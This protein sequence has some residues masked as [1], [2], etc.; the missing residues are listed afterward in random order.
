MSDTCFG[1][2]RKWA[3]LDAAAGASQCARTIQILTEWMEL[4][5]D[6]DKTGTMQAAR[7]DE[8]VGHGGS[9]VAAR[10]TYI[11]QAFF[12]CKQ[13]LCCTLRY[14]MCPNLLC[15]LGRSCQANSSLCLPRVGSGQAAVG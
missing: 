12:Q 11:L 7:V 6:S 10:C 2:H 9:V 3:V 4:Q 8:G 14:S 5:A 1:A 15:H 13:Q